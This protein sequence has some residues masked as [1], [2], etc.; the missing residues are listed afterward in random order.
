MLNSIRQFVKHKRPF[1]YI[2]F[3]V[4]HFIGFTSSDSK[5]AITRFLSSTNIV[6]G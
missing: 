2:V 4:Y 6:G 5:A 1:N 3:F